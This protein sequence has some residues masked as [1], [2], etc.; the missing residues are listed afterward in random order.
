MAAIATSPLLITLNPNNPQ[1]SEVLT[2]YDLNTDTVDPM[3]L[4]PHVRNARNEPLLVLRIAQ[5]LLT[6]N[7]IS[8]QNHACN[9]F[10][11]FTLGPNTCPG[12]GRMFREWV[13]SVC[14]NGL[15]FGL[16][17]ASWK[18]PGDSGKILGRF[19]ANGLEA[20]QE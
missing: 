10:K 4:K 14:G 1:N 16:L 17:Q 11:S 2:P 5:L 8:S 6:K 7:P 3:Y 12:F 13:S 19:T 15:N 18:G 20:M 9:A